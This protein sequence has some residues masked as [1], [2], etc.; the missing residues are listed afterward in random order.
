LSL[1][2]L[3][4][5][6]ISLVRWLVTHRFE[7][8]WVSDL[9]GVATLVGGVLVAWSLTR[10][11]KTYAV[12]LI[13]VIAGTQVQVWHLGLVFTGLLTVLA[14]YAFG[15]DALRALRGD[16]RPAARLEGDPARLAVG[17]LS[18]LVA[19]VAAIAVA[20]SAQ[21]LLAILPDVYSE[22][23][24][25]WPWIAMLAVIGVL[26]LAIAARRAGSARGHWSLAAG[27]WTA[28]LLSAATYPLWREAQSA[29]VIVGV[30]YLALLGGASLLLLRRALVADGVIA[31]SPGRNV[32]AII[33][34]GALGILIG[35]LVNGPS[36]IGVLVTCAL[37]VGGV[38]SLWVEL[39]APRPSSA[40][41]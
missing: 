11:K 18:V 34:G 23:A 29:V 38:V 20:R 22:V 26:G 7:A 8:F 19:S 17:T 35:P 39:S 15:G 3:S 37:A 14:L 24:E 16:D 33:A 10:W 1:V 5:T 31:S 40:P 2:G 28:F 25:V 21:A 27:V 6:V 13:V 32:I 36:V 12:L 41:A 9:G 30:C 4:L